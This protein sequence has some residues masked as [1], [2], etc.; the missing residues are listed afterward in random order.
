[1]FGLVFTRLDIAINHQSN[2]CRCVL[3]LETHCE[4]ILGE[5]GSTG[6]GEER[7]ARDWLS[8]PS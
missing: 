2:T 8:H 3:V 6:S 5:E 1:M 7:V 4:C